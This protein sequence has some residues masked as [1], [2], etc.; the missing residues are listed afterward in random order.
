MAVGTLLDKLYIL[1][2][3]VAVA[4][5]TVAPDGEKKTGANHFQE[6]RQADGPGINA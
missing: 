6:D 4:G 1:Q 5:Q 2:S 3:G